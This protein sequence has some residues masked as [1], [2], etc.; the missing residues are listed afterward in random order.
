[1]KRLM[2]SCALSAFHRV[3]VQR[4]KTADPAATD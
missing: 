2:L 4:G 3:R 1:M